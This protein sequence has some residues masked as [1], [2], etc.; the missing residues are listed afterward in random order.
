M[1]AYDQMWE[2]TFGTC[3]FQFQIWYQ[4]CFKFGKGINMRYP[5]FHDFCWK[6]L[7]WE[8]RGAEW[9][10]THIRLEDHSLV[11]G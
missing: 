7:R 5:E 10:K 1:V 9:K 3:T 6:G 4:L 8:I 11:G 2:V